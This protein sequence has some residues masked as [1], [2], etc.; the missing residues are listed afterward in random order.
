MQNAREVIEAKWK[1]GEKK[2]RNELNVMH[3]V[4]FSISLMVKKR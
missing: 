2:L 3:P 1:E 4:H